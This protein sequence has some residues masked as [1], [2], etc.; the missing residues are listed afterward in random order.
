MRVAIAAGEAPATTLSA[1]AYE[2]MMPFF[3]RQQM[4]V[5]SRL[6][7]HEHK[8]A[9]FSPDLP[10]QVVRSLRRSLSLVRLCGVPV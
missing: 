3:S 1:H 8:E 5:R 2:E 6:F 10:V 7:D 9:T 4:G